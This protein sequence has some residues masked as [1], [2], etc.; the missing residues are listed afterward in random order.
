M[1]KLLVVLTILSFI[2]LSLGSSNALETYYNNH[3]GYNN[4]IPYSAFFNGH[5]AKPN[6][7]KVQKVTKS[8][9]AIQ[10]VVPVNQAEEKVE[11]KG[12]EGK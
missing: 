10:A 8:G 3:S 9:K 12:L 11:Q 1:N 2:F 7:I 5:S 4:K 6:K